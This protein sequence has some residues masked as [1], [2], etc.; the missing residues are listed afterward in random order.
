MRRNGRAWEEEKVQLQLR[1]SQLESEIKKM[2]KEKRIM[3]RAHRLEMISRV[4]KEIAI[5]VCVLAFLCV[6][7]FV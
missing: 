3:Q 5:V 6:R 2:N 7:A 4:R 1:I